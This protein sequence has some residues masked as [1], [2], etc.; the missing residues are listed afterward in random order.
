MTT[1]QVTVEIM[2]RQ[3]TIGT[4]SSER[5]IL[6]RAVD[7]LNQKIAAIQAASKKMDTDKVVMM[8]ALN[9]T[10]ELLKLADQNAKKALSNTHDEHK[11]AELIALCDNALKAN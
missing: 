3:F 5:E 2:N 6:L 4:P 9:L 10:H 11:I 7:M 1:Q 8:A